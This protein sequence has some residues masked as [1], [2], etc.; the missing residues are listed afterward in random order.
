MQNEYGSV[1]RRTALKVTGGSIAT[2]AASGLSAAEPG[3]T[4]EV[5]VGFTN[6]TGRKAA[7]NAATDVSR[8]FDFDALTLQ[9]P[10]QAVSGLANNP[11]VRYVEENGTWQALAQTLPWGVNR[12]DAD[13]SW[14]CSQATYGHVAIIDTGIDPNH[15][16]LDPNLGYGGSW[17][18]SSW[19]DDNGHGT[20][21]A[22]IVG[23]D[24]NS[25]GVTGVAPS[26]NLHAAKVLDSNGSGY[27]S[28][29]A[30]GI[31]WTANQG[32]DVG[33]LSLGGGHSSVVQ[34]ACQYAYNSGVLLVAAA[35]NNYGGS[36]SYPAAYG[37]CIAVSATDRY[38]NLASYSN[39]GPQVELAAPGSDIYS[40]Y[41]ND[42]YATLSGT[43]MATPHVA[44]AGAML[45]SNGYTHTGARSRLQNT[46]E[47][48]G[49]SSYQQGYGLLD[50]QAAL[51]CY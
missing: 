30:A 38:D 28:D 50:V 8:E 24:Y 49:L 9:V 46:A 20:H 4:V 26:A 41:W 25:Y 13:R 42:T 27:W 18:G 43:S 7:L 29:I 15:P 32:F 12:V 16:D 10:E 21:C 33:S 19:S 37:E 39:T 51:S 48:I 40:T 14:T 23:A 11:N 1:S 31:E 44:A 22:G 6:D 36:V 45:M 2:V 17:V 47:N 5:N 3:K 35:G 34:D